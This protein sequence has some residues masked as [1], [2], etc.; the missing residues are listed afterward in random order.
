MQYYQRA[1]T[2]WQVTI[3]DPE[4][5]LGAALADL[6]AEVLQVA[7]LATSAVFLAEIEGAGDPERGITQLDADWVAAQELLERLRF[8]V[9]LDWATLCFHRE[10]HESAGHCDG[11]QASIASCVSCSV[12]AVRVIDDSWVELFTRDAALAAAVSKMRSSA[13]LTSSPLEDMSFP[14]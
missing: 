4:L 11:S 9:Q 5:S 13:T 2:W 1:E 12:M 14:G 8:T 3:A 10:R 7:G 6:L